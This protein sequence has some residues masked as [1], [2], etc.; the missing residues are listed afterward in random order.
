MVG[1]LTAGIRSCF[2]NVTLMNERPL[3]KWWLVILPVVLWIGSSILFTFVPTLEGE[4]ITPVH[5]LIPAA[6]LLVVLFPTSIEPWVQRSWFPLAFASWLGSTIPLTWFTFKWVAGLSGRC[7]RALIICGALAFAF[8]VGYWII[9]VARRR[10]TS[11]GGCVP[12][13]RP[14]TQGR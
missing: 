5:C 3:N 13:A 14:T 4:H 12:I 9:G 11:A 7:D 8:F 6:F 10:A 1:L 2:G